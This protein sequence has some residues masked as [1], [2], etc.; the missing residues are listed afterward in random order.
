M[1]PGH[2]SLQ[3]P[4][5]WQATGNSK[6]T[7]VKNAKALSLTKDLM[8]RLAA[9]FQESQES[10]GFAIS[11]ASL[12]MLGDRSEEASGQENL[13]IGSVYEELL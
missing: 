4:R 10:R 5:D 2:G 11:A 3:E 6:F 1:N 9:A 7:A 8:T 13:P 12:V